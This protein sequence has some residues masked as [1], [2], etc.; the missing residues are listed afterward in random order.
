MI[1]DSKPIRLFHW[2]LR[3]QYCPLARPCLIQAETSLLWSLDLNAR[4]KALVKHR[5]DLIDSDGVE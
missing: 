1:Q 2:H 4:Q 5:K 3:S